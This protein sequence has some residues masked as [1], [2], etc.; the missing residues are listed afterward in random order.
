M[1]KNRAS[2]LLFLMNYYVEYFCRGMSA[3]CCPYSVVYKTQYSS[4]L[5]IAGD[6]YPE[7]TRGIAEIV[8]LC[9]LSV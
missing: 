7:G 5:F 6:L 3:R 8:T 1:N 4:P 9:S 2:A